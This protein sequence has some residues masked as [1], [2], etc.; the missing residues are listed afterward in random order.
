MPT[1][2]LRLFHSDEQSVEECAGLLLGDPLDLR[3]AEARIEGLAL[4]ERLRSNLVGAG[5]HTHLETHLGLVAAVRTGVPKSAQ[6][7]D[8]SVNAFP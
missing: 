5:S 3:V 2:L 4:S 6:E 7:G 1:S 8:L